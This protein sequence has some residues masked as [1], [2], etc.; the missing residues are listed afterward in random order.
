MCLTLVPAL[1]I[2]A[3][4]V[5]ITGNDQFDIFAQIRSAPKRRGGVRTQAAISHLCIR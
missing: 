4:L 1:I 3:I 2:I 5:V